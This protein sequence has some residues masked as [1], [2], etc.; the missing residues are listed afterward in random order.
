M[1]G[2]MLAASVLLG[3]CAMLGGGDEEEDLVPV[4]IRT[5]TLKAHEGANDDS[6]IR[7]DLVRVDDL[8]LYRELIGQDRSAWFATGATAFQQANPQAWMQRYEI[9]PG[10][11]AGPFDVG[12]VRRCGRGPAVRAA[13]GGFRGAQGGA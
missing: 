6:P 3:G 5:V 4:D 13:G 12:A 1:R 9:V 11:V 7:V 10:T 8:G 2:W